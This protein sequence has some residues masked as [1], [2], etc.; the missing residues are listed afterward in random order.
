MLHG[1]C[2]IDEL[3][4]RWP[5]GAVQVLRKIP[6]G[7]LLRAQEGRAAVVETYGEK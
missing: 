2:I 3:T 1:K 6:A 4:I 5:T 7:S